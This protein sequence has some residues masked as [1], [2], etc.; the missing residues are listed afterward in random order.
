MNFQRHS[1]RDGARRS[2]GLAWS[3]LFLGCVG[4]LLG[5][6]LAYEENTTQS[7]GKSFVPS[8]GNDPDEPPMQPV[9]VGD[10][11]VGTLPVMQGGSALVLRRDLE[12]QVPSFF[13]EGNVN[14]VRNAMLMTQGDALAKVVPLDPTTGRVRLVFPGRVAIALDRVMVESCGLEFGLVVPEPSTYA[15]PIGVWADRSFGFVPQSS[16]VQLPVT[17]MSALGALDVAPLRVTAPG[18]IQSTSFQAASTA[19]VLV[20]R[21]QH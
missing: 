17:Q 8:N 21:Q 6:V 11:T 4:F 16:L 15:Y 18:V 7:R 9:A 5:P 3:A 1:T 14:D 19:D 2:S 12:I 10:E 20:L 13:I